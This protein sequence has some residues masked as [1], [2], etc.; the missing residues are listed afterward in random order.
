MLTESSQGDLCRSSAQSPWRLMSV[1]GITK[2]SRLTRPPPST[3]TSSLAC[4]TG[5][6]N[7]VSDTCTVISHTLMNTYMCTCPDTYI[8]IHACT[9]RHMC[10]HN[11]TC[12]DTHIDA[13]AHIC[14]YRHTCTQTHAFMYACMCSQTCN[15]HWFMHAHTV[16]SLGTLLASG[17]SKPC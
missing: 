6:R 16:P 17:S 11:N 2:P 4:A 7:S 9:H 12:I 1:T 13:H 3:K 10:T 8:Y 14:P 5:R 15:A